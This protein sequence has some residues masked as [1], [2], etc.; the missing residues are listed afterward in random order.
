VSGTGFS[1]EYKK[2][3]LVYA[4]KAVARL[5]ANFSGD[6]LTEFTQIVDGAW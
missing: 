3:N 6:C 5:G 2:Q 4:P 1:F